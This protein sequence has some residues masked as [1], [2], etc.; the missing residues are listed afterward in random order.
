MQVTI[1]LSK[2]YARGNPWNPISGLY[3]AA[4]ENQDGMRCCLGFCA[5]S[6]GVGALC[7]EAEPYDVRGLLPSSDWMLDLRL[8]NSDLSML[9]MNINDQKG[10]IC[11]EE[12]FQ[13][14]PIE[15]RMGNLITIFAEGGDELEFVL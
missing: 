11:D 5:L 9:A 8:F 14:D 13:D 4:L 6:H 10:L 7:D 3:S 1:E 2:W 15:I 12:R